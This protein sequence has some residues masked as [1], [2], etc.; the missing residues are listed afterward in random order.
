[1]TDLTQLDIRYPLVEVELIGQDGN[2]FSILGKVSKA[3]QRAGVSADIRD[4]YMAQATA[5]D[6]DH[7]LRTTMQWV[8]VV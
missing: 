5:G 8:T 1:M 7:L 2:A 6:Y 4:E 3:L